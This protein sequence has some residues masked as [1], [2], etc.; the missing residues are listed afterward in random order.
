MP[1]VPQAENRTTM[2]AMHPEQ[3]SHKRRLVS[4]MV[5]NE[6][7]G[8]FGSRE[9]MYLETFCNVIGEGTDVHGWSSPKNLTVECQERFPHVCPS[10]LTCHRQKTH[11]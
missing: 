4:N 7:L 1:M 2:T 11:G 10:K 3:I 9:E 5:S 6:A 8:A